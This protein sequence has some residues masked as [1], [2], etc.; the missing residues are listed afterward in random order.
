[1]K[2]RTY[3][4]AELKKAVVS[5][6]SV[7]ETLR[8]LGL[9][10]AGG[11]HATIKKLC[12]DYK[13]CTKHFKGQAHMTGKSNPY[14]KRPLKD[15]LVENSTYSNTWNLKLR[16]IKEGIKENKCEECGLEDWLGKPIAMHLDHV[17]G[18]KRDN[19]LENLKMLCPN[20]HSQTPTYC[21][22]NI[23]KNK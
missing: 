16:L 17:N 22:R 8:K 21:G 13:I 12:E 5:S 4:I 2:T 20:C 6:I 11:N 18:V 14:N 10:P 3:T 15:I 9:K 23:G 19:R 7:S 1:M